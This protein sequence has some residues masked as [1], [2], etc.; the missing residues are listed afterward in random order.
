MFGFPAAVF[1]P[2]LYPVPAVPQWIDQMFWTVWKASRYNSTT[3]SECL[4]DTKKMLIEPG[5]A[6]AAG[7]ISESIV[8]IGLFRNLTPVFTDNLVSC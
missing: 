1:S 4:E 8:F 7:Y 3:T 6:L 2:A 5:K